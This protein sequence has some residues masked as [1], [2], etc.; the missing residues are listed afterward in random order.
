MNEE[1]EIKAIDIG[2]TRGGAKASYLANHYTTVQRE[3]NMVANQSEPLDMRRYRGLLELHIADIANEHAQN[4]MRKILDEKFEAECNMYCQKYG[5]SIHDL[6]AEYID[7]A[8]LT[9]CAC[10]KGL[11]TLYMDQFVAIEDRYE[12]MLL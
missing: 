1:K 11:I 10:V 7:S 5:Y 2:I 8:M 3:V 12:V 6:P 9:A 4:E